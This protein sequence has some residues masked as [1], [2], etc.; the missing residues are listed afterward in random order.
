MPA[1]TR[2]GARA[3]VADSYRLWP[4]W[5][6][7]LRREAPALPVY[8]VD[9]L[10]EK[11]GMPVHGFL[12]FGLGADER[13]YAPEARADSLVGAAYTPL[14]PEFRHRR[15]RPH[16]SGRVL[17]LM[18][19]SDPER[20]TERAVRALRGVAEVRHLDVVLGPLF[21][22]DT[23]VRRAAAGD[24]RVRLHVAPKGLPQLM[25]AADVAVSASGMAATELAA[26]GV[27][28]VLLAL[29]ENQR[30]NG[31]G[32]RRLGTALYL[33]PY[34]RVSEVALAGAVSRLLKDA[35]MRGRLSAAGR[36]AL[37]G[38][39]AE[40]L[41]DALLD[42]LDAYHRDRWPTESV[43]REYERS[44]S[45]RL[46]HQKARWGSDQGM[47]NRF[48]LVGR[49]VRWRGVRDWL[50]VGCGTGG[51]LRELE[52][53]PGLRRY[54][55]ADLSPSVVRQARERTY[56]TR[57][58]RFVVAGLEG[59]IPGGPFDLV[60]SL[61]VL[62][63]CGIPLRKAVALMAARLRSGGQLFVT[64]K[65]LDWRRFKEPGFRPEPSHHWHRL[66]ELRRAA[67][68]A[69][70]RDTRVGGLI[71]ATG[72]VVAPKASHDVFLHAFKA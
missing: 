51:L 41:A 10:G 67:E 43:R 42:R 70:L 59:R 17:V 4:A 53:R 21:G 34:R 39:G 30:A 61:G 55:G 31:E 46:D 54:T 64:T 9:D 15:E 23:A 58:T 47:R 18:G 68:L 36:A 56:H 52:P 11:A 37:D 71:P 29:A 27:P 2:A 26:L 38:R 60:T 12:S 1:L 40:R 45:A 65:N 16:F 44:A 14:R 32:A 20:Q 5:F 7:T 3:L 8:A 13:R 25:A 72:R 66:S 35:A 63:K 57:R 19:G 6:E 49:A 62:Q 69:G 28:A 48:R 22:P 33:G 24:P 50:D